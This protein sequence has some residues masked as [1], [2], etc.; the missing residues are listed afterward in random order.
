MES[1]A[2]GSRG[3]ALYLSRKATVFERG[4]GPGECALCA[5]RGLQMAARQEGGMNTFLA[6]KPMRGPW[7]GVAQILHFNWRMYLATLLGT[8][9]VLGAWPLLPAVGRV[10]VLAAVVP[11]LFWLL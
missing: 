9:A 11:A 2:G 1:E 10:L 7:Q 8:T 6:V 5:R 3:A 4:A